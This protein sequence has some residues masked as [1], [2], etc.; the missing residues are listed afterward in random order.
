MLAHTVLFSLHDAS[1]AACRTLVDACKRDL[2]GHPGT[3][4]F[5]VG[6]RAAD[7]DW[8]V[9]DRDFDV[10]LQLV[11]KD[12]DAHDTYQESK[13][14]QRFLEQHEANWRA[15]RVIDAYVEQ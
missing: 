9:S 12:R 11:F 14:H 4:F 1:P 8:S 3:V 13:Q 15:I 7:I 2:S 5:A 10:V 6:T